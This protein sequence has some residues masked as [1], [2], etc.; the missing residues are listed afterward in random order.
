MTEP[1]TLSVTHTDDGASSAEARH[2]AP[3]LYLAFEGERPSG[4]GMRVALG[5]LDELRFGRGRERAFTTTGRT[6]ELLIPDPR[7][8][9]KHARLRRL[10]DG[11]FLLEDLGSTNGSFV[12][13]Q[14]VESFA[15]AGGGE[16][17][18][19]LGATAFLYAEEETGAGTAVVIDSASR[20]SR[21]RGMATLVPHQDEA[22]PRLL[23][24][25]LSTL[26]ILLLGPSG[27]GK[28]VLARTIH[29]ISG[30]AGPF[31]AINCGALAPALVEG[32]L[33]G[34]VKGAFSGALKDEPG[35]IRSA[36]QGTL[37]LDEIGELP[38]AA[39]ATLLR[40]LQEREV[41]PVGATK[42]VPVDVRILSAT[43][44]SIDESPNFRPDL[45]ARISA[46]V[47]RIPPLCERKAD[48]G[49]LV[50]DL[51]PRVAPEQAEVT[52][53]AP[54]LVSALVAHDWPLN[55]R[56]LEHVL[57]VATVTATTALLRMEHVGAALTKSVKRDPDAA[58]A[59]SGTPK[60]PPK[61]QSDDD[62][63]GDV[64]RPLSEAEEKTK[65]ELVAMLEKTSGNV[66]EVSRL[67]GKTRMQIHR[68]AKRFGVDLESF[69]K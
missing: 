25:A 63:D 65:A 68:W 57:S 42:P 6:A 69:R 50:A 30:R 26:P 36:H 22:M 45:Y 51:L 15:F 41:L 66:S 4:G 27:S 52:R 67:M 28:E 47:H 37:L 60:G 53:F 32:L 24:V 44:R 59:P 35:L 21:P 16:Q 18:F 23:R 54:E 58:K 33:F 2:V 17:A 12:A 8:S 39:Q 34:H 3:A 56:E 55:V 48:L 11:T 46:F 29:E 31:V 13:Q 61:S 40:V 20:K 19:L 43:L 9:G 10:P 64:S 7:M 49:I 14:R 1:P 5:E 62:E 38:A